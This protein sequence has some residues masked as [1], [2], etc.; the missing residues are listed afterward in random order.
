MLA[1][2]PDN[3]LP[4]GLGSKVRVF[5]LRLRVPLLKRDTVHGCR[6]GANCPILHAEIR[7]KCVLLASV[8]IERH[9]KR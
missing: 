8:M 6:T 3:A 9:P 7:T 2:L 5:V 4:H 1:E